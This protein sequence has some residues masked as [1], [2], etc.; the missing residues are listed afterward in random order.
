MR[1]SPLLVAGLA[2]ATI[3]LSACGDSTESPPASP[4]SITLV[5]LNDFH[6]NLLP[7][8]GSVTVPSAGNAAGTRVSAGGSAYLASL[9]NDLRSKNANTLV[10]GAGDLIGA[11]PLVS[12]ALH[13]EPAVEVLNA[14]GVDFSAVGDQEFGRGVAELNRMQNGG[15]FP[16]S[17]DGSK[18]VVGVD[19]CLV[20]GKFS[21]AKFQYL[22]ANVVDAAT[23]KTLFPPYALRQYG[24]ERIAFVGVTLKEAPTLVNPAHT[25]GLLI[26]DEVE[27]VNALV[28]ELVQR[29]ASAIVVLLHQGGTT[30]AATV[31]D[32]TCPGLSADIAAMVD[33]LDARID[34]VMSGHSHSDYNCTRPDGRLLTQASPAG[35]TVSKINLTI[36]PDTHR[37][38]A[39]SADNLVVVND[40]PVKDAQGQVIPVPAGYTVL[41]KD[42]GVDGLVTRF[43]SL[44]NATT[45]QSIGGLQS[46]LTRVIL[47]SGES[48]VGD[49]AA[50]IYL[51]GTSTAAF[52][53]K[54]A[55]IAFINAGQVRGNLPNLSVTFGDLF[56]VMPFGNRLVSMD[57][58]GQQILRVLEQ[59]WESPQPAGGRV[60]Q[61]SN[62][63]TYTWDANLPANAAAGAGA[64]VVPGSVKLNGVALDPSKTYR[65]TVNDFLVSGGD[66]FSIFKSGK[67]LQYGDIDIEAGV[68]YFKSKGVV[69]TPG[70]DRIQRLN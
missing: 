23:G 45:T 21:G 15:C 28:P 35:R 64:R 22:A 3:G 9:V 57:L 25:N 24:G 70:M 29:G 65:V 16:R 34:V 26:K 4:V 7:P 19:T 37:V 43:Q 38:V 68:A 49:V 30:T 39:K 69:A 58:T 17:A 59:Q 61:V 41:S 46:A 62:G 53:S 27:T 55:Q 12:A 32:K 48:A 60:L 66:N 40:L 47:P 2:V 63:F 54:A 33:R 10:V 51:S 11:S 67:N 14:I 6:G 42:A 44:A 36:S 31:N 56:T 13:E 8:S 52:G 20:D 1:T 18:G 5:G 50:D